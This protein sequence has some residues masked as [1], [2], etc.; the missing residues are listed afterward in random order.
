MNSRL[1][2]ATPDDAAAIARIYAHYVTNTMIS[3]EEVAPSAEDMRERMVAGLATHPWLVAEGP[4]GIEAYAYAG[5][6]GA[7]AG[8]RW[9]ADVTVYAAQGRTRRG[10]GR[11]LYAALLE[12]LALQGMHRVYG[13]VGL[14]NDA[15]DG[16]HRAMGFREVGT[17]TR[18]GFKLGRWWDVRWFERSI[19]PDVDDPP[20]EP[21]AWS[22]LVDDARV[23]SILE[24]AAEAR[25]HPL[26]AEPPAPGRISL[27][28]AFAGF[29]DHW[30]PRIAAELNGQHIKLAKFQGAF[31]WH[32]HAN[33]DE[34]FL[35]VRGRFRME[36]RDH[37]VELAEGEFLVV[38][39]G[40]E[41]R[42]VADEEVQ[43]LLFEPA[44][45]LNTG[46]ADDPRARR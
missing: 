36:F 5:P 44:G 10:L 31:V 27:A 24:R 28:E 11:A 29:S 33:E 20:A 19:A 1:R 46:D 37:Q 18:V 12:L 23:A 16:L 35:V 6:H 2:L 45:T 43:V 3:F 34:M 7:R 30:H 21:V 26:V 22:R 41:H 32:R 40:V 14:P 13:G 42:P 38:P 39:R 4:G 15:S 25:P 17:Y 9:S 8:Y